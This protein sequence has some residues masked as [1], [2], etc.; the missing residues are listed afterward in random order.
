MVWLQGEDWRGA[1]A[2]TEVQAGAIVPL[3]SPPLTQPVGAGAAY[4]NLQQPE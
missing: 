4:A 3:F 2:Q 1:L